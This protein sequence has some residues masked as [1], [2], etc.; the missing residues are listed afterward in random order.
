[1]AEPNTNLPALSK[2]DIDRFRSKIAVGAPGECWPWTG[3]KGRRGYGLFKVRR[4]QDGICRML[5]AHRVSY[6]LATG[7]DPGKFLILH[8]CDNPCCNNP[9]HLSRGTCKENMLDAKAKSRTLIGMKNKRAIFSD[10]QVVKIRALYAKCRRKNRFRR[11]L[12][13]LFCCC[14]STIQHIVY[15]RTWTHLL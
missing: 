3:C 1:M 10:E 7:V 9:A 8:S 15:E 13:K 5:K 11:K 14:E 4:K 2:Q 12:A 6:F